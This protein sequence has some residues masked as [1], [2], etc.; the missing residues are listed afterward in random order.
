[1]PNK[2]FYNETG[3]T[4]R[5]KNTEVKNT[6]LVSALSYTRG[7]FCIKYLT[8]KPHYDIYKTGSCLYAVPISLIEMKLFK[9]KRTLTKKFRGESGKE[10]WPFR[11]H[12]QE[13]NVAELVNVN[14]LQIRSR[15]KESTPAG[16]RRAGQKFRNEHSLFPES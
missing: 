2:P 16:G 10:F 15:R 14:T 8:E 12:F 11:E 4:L 13:D 3:S 1:M 5:Q 7:Q 9:K 6:A